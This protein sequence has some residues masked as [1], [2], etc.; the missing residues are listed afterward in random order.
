MNDFIN[1]ISRKIHQSSVRD[2]INLPLPCIMNICPQA[3]TWNILMPP[4][5]RGGVYFCTPTDFELGY[6]IL[7]S[8]SMGRSGSVSVLRE[9]FQQHHLY[10]LDPVELL[11][12]AWVPE[13]NVYKA[14]LAH[15]AGKQHEA[16]LNLAEKSHRHSQRIAICVSEPLRFWGHL[17][18]KKRLLN[19]AVSNPTSYGTSK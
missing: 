12:S 19:T 1:T 13:R 10:F 4:R 5:W 7:L 18:K 15:N 14:D 9:G 16:Q 3:L 17:L 6:V 11:H 2:W 8:S